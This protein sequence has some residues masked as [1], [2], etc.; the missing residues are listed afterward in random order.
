M[1]TIDTYRGLIRPGNSLSNLHTELSS[2]GLSLLN[3]GR[4]N[5]KLGAR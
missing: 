1:R 3:L 5:G 2:M 4:D